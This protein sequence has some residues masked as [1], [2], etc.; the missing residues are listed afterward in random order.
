[1]PGPALAQA[2]EIVRSIIS[3][4]PVNGGPH[5]SRVPSALVAVALIERTLAER[6]GE[7]ERREQAQSLLRLMLQAQTVSNGDIIAVLEVLAGLPARP[8]E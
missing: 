3:D 7:R 4:I 1:M 5:P 8:R 2:I 6:E